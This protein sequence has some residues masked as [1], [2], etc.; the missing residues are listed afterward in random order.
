MALDY[1]V[2]VECIGKV[3]FVSWDRAHQVSKR[4]KRKSQRRGYAGSG[5]GVYRCP[6]CRQWHIGSRTD[7]RKGRR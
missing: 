5:M 1:S 7:I 2:P 4:S 6:C 3:A